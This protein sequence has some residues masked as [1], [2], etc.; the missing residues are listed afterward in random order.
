MTDDILL[1]KSGAAA[2][3]PDDH[4]AVVDAV[5]ALQESPGGSTPGGFASA[6]FTFTEQ[7]TAGTYTA[8]LPLPAGT[9]VWDI[10]VYPIVGQWA[11]DAYALDVGDTLNGSQSYFAGASWSTDYDPTNEGPGLNCSN[12]RTDGN[13]YNRAPLSVQAGTAT[14]GPLH[15]TGVGVFYPTSDTLVMSLTTTI[16]SPP[17]VP[18]GVLRLKVIYFAPVTAVAAAFA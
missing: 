2:V 6:D 18:T 15:A 5:K 4:N 17:V 14:S 10:L 16:G 7:A 13:I 11:A 8:S 12:V 3:D 1:H 9:V